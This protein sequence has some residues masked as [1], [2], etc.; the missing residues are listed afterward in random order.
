MAIISATPSLLP[1]HHNLQLCHNSSSL[2]I[3]AVLQFTKFT[4]PLHGCSRSTFARKEPSLNGHPFHVSV[5]K[6]NL[7]AHSSPKPI[8]S[9]EVGRDE[10]QEG[11]DDCKV[12]EDHGD[13]DPNNKK[14][15]SSDDIF[16]D[17]GKVALA[18]GEFLPPEGFLVLVASIVGVLTGISVV[19]FNL[20]VHEVRDI[21]WDGIPIPGA[22]WLRE[23][24]LEQKWQR[25]VLIPACGGVVVGIL[26]TLR[27]S[28]ESYSEGIHLSDIKASFRSFLKT[29]AATITLGTGNSLG[30]E[31]PSVE[32]G[33][34]IAQGIGK[35][36]QCSKGMRLS[37]IATGS[38]AGISSGFNAP[39]AGCFFAV[40]SVL[41]PSS[42]DFSPSLTNTTSMVI[43]SAVI[44]SV[45]SQAGLGS[46][47][48]FTIPVYEF[49][50]PAELPLYLQLG[51]LSGLVSVVLSKTTTFAM[52]ASN[53]LL[54]I[55]GV[56]ATLLPPLGGI[57]V[58]LIALAYPEVLYW[59]FENVDILLES[60][61]FQKSPPADLL[62][63]LVGAK[64]VATSL[65]RASGLVGGYYA[66]SLF[67]GAALG[68]AY[69]KLAS[70]AVTH[71]NP[72]FHL[73]AL[74]V[75]P[76]QAYALV[77][78]A[79]TLAGVCQVPLTSV[80]LLFELTHDYRIIIPLMGA[81]GFS[82]WISSALTRKM[83]EKLN[84]KKLIS[85]NVNKR[86]NKQ[87]LEKPLFVFQQSEKS[88]TSSVDLV[89]PLNLSKETVLHRS[90]LCQLESSVCVEN[91]NFKEEQLED[92]IPVAAA[93][94]TRYVTVFQ[95]TSVQDAMALMLAE[96]E[97][98]ALVVDSDD[99]LKGILTLGDIQ[100]YGK[101]ARARTRASSKLVEVGIVPVSEVCTSWNGGGKG[102]ELLT[103]FP[104]SSLKVARRLM[105]VHGLR[106]LPVVGEAA[107]Q[108]DRMGPLVGLLDRD[109][110]NLACRA[111][112]TKWIVGLPCSI[113]D[114]EAQ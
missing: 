47:P 27:S 18:I 44:A 81:V 10:I 79:A 113:Q 75:A 93:M 103:V 20:T 14:K 60:Q 73:D 12:V 107:S 63:Q 29:V 53:A 88:Q 85:S 30:P 101:M 28:L 9:E 8:D 62:L 6:R 48:A 41:W 39:V 7:R 87:S 36:L 97:W 71:A 3:S 23:Q 56:P 108:V 109:C 69:G 74:E 100:Q 99:Y 33:S 13:K 34:S 52:T 68:S 58:G 5:W 51:I 91:P 72:L 46:D 24:P 22:S 49:R 50:S 112:V 35:V 40:E 55:T 80:L 66:P 11:S 94:R 38:A 45:I 76:P 1:S 31:G 64:I 54:E 84:D 43:L 70:Y 67:I 102:L 95:H 21:F 32:I 17:W 19:L 110:V 89:Q 16:A 42:A 77:G 61:P 106:Q 98:C 26:N 90:N 59:G 83:N 57:S 37:L 65:S 25:V 114:S 2:R 15:E 86:E 4:F 82:S 96:K 105:A 92:L 104:H 111:E 78:M